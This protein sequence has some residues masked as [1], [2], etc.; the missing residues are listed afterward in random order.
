MNKKGMNKWIIALIIIVV[1]V[2]GFYL[3]NRNDDSS[4]DS[5]NE[6]P[7]EFDE[8]NAANLETSNDDFNEID[9]SI[10]YLE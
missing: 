4:T 6:N 5:Q 3:M 10:D 9:N 8:T 2:A 7:Q 1:L